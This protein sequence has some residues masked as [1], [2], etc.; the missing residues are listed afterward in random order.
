M[1]R[2]FLT[3]WFKLGM[4]RLVIRRSRQDGVGP[5]RQYHP[6]AVTCNAHTSTKFNTKHYV[7]TT[8]TTAAAAVVSTPVVLY[9]GT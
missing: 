6:L 7:T 8:C 1:R 9:T 2:Q 4:F 3:A 5:A